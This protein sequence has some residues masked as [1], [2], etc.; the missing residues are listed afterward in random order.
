M[1]LCY[2]RVCAVWRWNHYIVG[3]YGVSWLSVI[4]SNVTMIHSIKPLQVEAN[5]TVIIVGGQLVLAPFIVNVVNHTLVFMAITYGICKNT[6]RE[7]LTFKHGIMV[8]FGNSLPT[9]SK[10]LLHDSQI[11]Y[12]YVP[13]PSPNVLEH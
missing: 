6:L 11:S 9:F 10:A 5:C 1:S 2:L 8:M 3:F 13:L 7:D 12:M 4:A